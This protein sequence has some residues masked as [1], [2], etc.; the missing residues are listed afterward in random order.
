MSTHIKA[1]VRSVTG[2]G[3]DTVSEHVR[4]PEGTSKLLPSWTPSAPSSRFTLLK[5]RTHSLTPK[6]VLTHK[7]AHPNTI[8]E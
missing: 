7:P 1:G 6:P 4:E 5:A 3:T 2:L 8:N